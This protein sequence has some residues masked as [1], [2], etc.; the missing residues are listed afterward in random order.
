MTHPFIAAVISVAVV[1]ALAW[2]GLTGYLGAHPVAWPFQVALIGAPI[3]AGLALIA[4]MVARSRSIRVIA[5]V[6][7]LAAALGIARYG[8][9]EFAASFAEDRLAGQMWYFGWIATCAM[10]ASV[11]TALLGR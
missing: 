9:T 5:F 7:L 4:G 3:G 8:G 1:L 2:F 10:A 6:V 11:L